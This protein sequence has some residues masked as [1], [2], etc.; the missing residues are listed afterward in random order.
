[1]QEIDTQHKLV[2]FEVN[3]NTNPMTLLVGS[4]FTYFHILMSGMEDVNSLGNRK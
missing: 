3:G 2:L 1:M 4:L